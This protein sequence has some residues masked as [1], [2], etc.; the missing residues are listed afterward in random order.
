MRRRGLYRQIGGRLVW[1]LY[2]LDGYV[3]VQHR[4]DGK[5]ERIDGSIFDL[6]YEWHSEVA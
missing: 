6:F 2:E 4:A 5:I 1:L 3:H